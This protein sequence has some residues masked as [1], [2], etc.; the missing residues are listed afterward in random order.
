V[1][2]GLFWTFVNGKADFNTSLWT[3]HYELF[4]SFAAYVTGLVLISQK[5]FVRSMAAGVIVLLLTATL[6][7]EGGVYYAMLII[8][9]LIARIYPER[10]T[11]AHALPFMNPW[12]GPIALA[13][14]SLSVILFGFD[15][16]SKPVGFYIFMAS[17]GSPKAEPL[18]HAAAAVAIVVV[19]LFYDPIQKRL[20]GRPPV[21][22]DNCPFRS[23]SCI[24][25]FCAV[26]S[27]PSILAWRIVWAASPRHRWHL[28][29][30]LHSR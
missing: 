25:L 4:G 21:Y 9:A 22:S 10:D 14:I 16:Y 28:P 1:A 20:M 26:S 18:I 13:V 19:V 23:I 8:G 2:E 11:L 3:M 12:R 24:C 27:L 17:L 5:S 15:G 30:R 6:T 7:G 29:C